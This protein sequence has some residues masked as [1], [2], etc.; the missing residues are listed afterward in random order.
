MSNKCQPYHSLDI[1]VYHIFS[2]CTLGNNIEIDKRMAGEGGMRL[3]KI[4][5]VIKEERR[6]R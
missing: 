2:D 3:C 1:D 5:E 6:Q 4:F